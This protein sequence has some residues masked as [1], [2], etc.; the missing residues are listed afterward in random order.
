ME[1]YYPSQLAPSR[2]NDPGVISY[3]GYKYVYTDDRRASTYS[4]NA[5]VYD[6]AATR[7]QSA[8]RGFKTRKMSNIFVPPP[9]MKMESAMEDRLVEELESLS[10]LAPKGK[11]SLGSISES[12]RALTNEIDQT[13]ETIRKSSLN[14]N[15][16]KAASQIQSLF[17][18]YQV[19]KEFT[20]DPQEGSR[21]VRKSLDSL[22]ASQDGLIA[23]EDR[24]GDAA[25]KIQS[26]FRGHIVRKSL[27]HNIGKLPEVEDVEAAVKIQAVFRGHKA[28]KQYPGGKG[29]RQSESAVSQIRNERPQPESLEDAAVKIQALFRGHQARRDFVGDKGR[30][31]SESNFTDPSLSERDVATR[32]R[33][34]ISGRPEALQ[35]IEKPIG[36]FSTSKEQPSDQEPR[37]H[38]S[39]EVETE[40][41][42][43]DKPVMAHDSSEE[44]SHFPKSEESL[45]VEIQSTGVNETVDLPRNDEEK[46]TEVTPE[47]EYKEAEKKITRGLELAEVSSGSKEEFRDHQPEETEIENEF[48]RDID[49]IERNMRL[50]QE[51]SSDENVD[52]NSGSPILI[53]CE[54]EMPPTDSE[55]LFQGSSSYELGIE[56]QDEGVD[57]E[58]E[59]DDEPDPETMDAVSGQHTFFEKLE[60]LQRAREILGS[61]AFLPNHLDLSFVSSED[62]SVE[63]RNPDEESIATVPQEFLKESQTQIELDAH[64]EDKSDNV[65][66]KE[67]F[68]GSTNTLGVRAKDSL[69]SSQLSLGGSRMLRKSVSTSR[70]ASVI[71][72]QGLMSDKIAGTTEEKQL[73]TGEV[74]PSVHTITKSIRESKVSLKDSSSESQT[75]LSSTY[76]LTSVNAGERRRSR[77]SFFEPMVGASRESKHTRSPPPGAKSDLDLATERLKDIL[78][79]GG[80]NEL[81][82]KA[83]PKSASPRRRI[84]PRSAGGKY[85]PTLKWSGFEFQR[86]PHVEALTEQLIDQQRA[87]MEQLNRLLVLRLANPW[88]SITNSE[89]LFQEAAW[90]SVKKSI[91]HHKVPPK[92]RRPASAP[93]AKR[94]ENITTIS[95][96]EERRNEYFSKLASPRP[97]PKEPTLLP[98]SVRNAHTKIG[99]IDW[100]RIESL[101]RPRRQNHPIT[102]E[103]A[104][105]AIQAERRPK[106]LK[107]MDPVV[108]ARLTKPRAKPEPPPAPPQQRPVSPRKRSI[109]SAASNSA[110]DVNTA[111]SQQNNE[112]SSSFDGGPAIFV[113]EHDDISKNN[114]SSNAER[115]T[116][117]PPAAEATISRDIS[118]RAEHILKQDGAEDGSAEIQI[119]DGVSII[120][121]T[122]IDAY[123]TN[124]SSAIGALDELKDINGSVLLGEDTIQPR[125]STGENMDGKPREESKTASQSELVSIPAS[126][127]NV[128]DLVELTKTEISAISIPSFTS[129]TNVAMEMEGSLQ[130]KEEPD[131]VE[132]NLRVT[133]MVELEKREP[134]LVSI[135]SL[136]SLKDLVSTVDVASISASLDVDTQIHDKTTKENVG[137]E[138]STHDPITDIASSESLVHAARLSQNNSS[139]SNVQAAAT[140][141]EADI[142]EAVDTARSEKSTSPK[143][144]SAADMDSFFDEIMGSRTSMAGEAHEVA[145]LENNLK[146]SREVVTE[147]EAFE[148]YGGEKSEIALEQVASNPNLG[149]I[150]G[151][152]SAAI[153][154]DNF[155]QSRDAISEDQDFSHPEEEKHEAAL[156][157]VASN[158]DLISTQ[159]HLGDS[160]EMQF[161]E[162]ENSFTEQDT[163]QSL[164]LGGEELAAESSAESISSELPVASED[165][166]PT[167]PEITAPET[168]RSTVQSS[169]DLDELLA[170]VEYPRAYQPATNGS[171]RHA[172]ISELN[173][174]QFE[175][176]DQAHTNDTGPRE[177]HIEAFVEVEARFQEDASKAEEFYNDE[178]FVQELDALRADS[179]ADS[180]NTNS[181]E[182]HQ[183]ASMEHQQQPQENEPFSDSIPFGD[184]QPEEHATPKSSPPHETTIPTKNSSQVNL[185][186][187]FFDL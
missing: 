129:L 126:T 90:E 139:S 171:E 7:V 77:V 143:L 178:E 136:A 22:Y 132:D 16:S 149:L 62:V 50:L 1:E 183:A 57:W 115:G 150:Q 106:K 39:S 44:H 46:L 31:K 83:R 33:H 13:V 32:G 116:D 14:L 5:S 93:L 102:P 187:P 104:M 119:I 58:S 34:T 18:G 66:S 118:N 134:S 127:N 162:V 21:R 12:L 48:T 153:L 86:M 172:S 19:R 159:S 137:P 61:D 133:T 28:R 169:F 92:K 97:K 165:L 65:P 166:P 155:R 2:Q 24:E 36:P 40:K 123:L 124:E 73:H 54:D 11:Q 88:S 71:V 110:R 47:G 53:E 173:P 175:N 10:D 151:E 52:C 35:H 157:Q 128:V 87:E 105:A 186:D 140:Q 68:A 177:S 100:E 85:N 64:L 37:N 60:E 27:S 113:D 20:G 8:F 122:D 23:E 56:I 15:E 55:L 121:K 114:S 144:V 158:P 167:A 43:D 180:E 160:Y 164:P 80:P 26:V 30:R 103:Q 41:T 176:Q 170:D 179:A 6:N 120:S 76:A 95:E 142:P 152:D 154:D 108:F 101:S 94:P 131:I 81:G 99:P 107:P 74:F 135:P 84:R 67:E 29:R 147:D 4:S 161:E 69:V 117:F 145:I 181:Y 141:E 89:L 148:Q 17:R 25:K 156:E 91:S 112:T 146:K 138:A 78:M 125:I 72:T 184:V 70:A 49:E 42:S 75:K 163:P 174:D 109:K 130:T 182:S 79:S 82:K 98:P 111:T 96:A 168:V 59:N 38:S 185:D 3:K 51:S 45:P 63:D 9:I